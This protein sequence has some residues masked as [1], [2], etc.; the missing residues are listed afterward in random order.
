MRATQILRTEHRVIEQVLSCLEA[1]A[2]RACFCGAVD[3]ESA[4]AAIDFFRNFADE[5][6]HAKEESHLFAM[7]EERGFSSAGGPT[8][9]MRSEHRLGRQHLHVMEENLEL[10]EAGDP[11]ALT[12]FVDAAWE[13]V[14]LL[15][16]HILKEDNCLF[17][18]ADRFLSGPD[19]T[20]LLERFEAAEDGGH[21]GKHARY[22]ALADKLAE[23]FGVT[24]AGEAPGCVH[25]GCGIQPGSS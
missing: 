12:R 9:V 17:P 13:Y 6:H 5:C 4:R 11:D 23:R 19:Q 3:G 18:M 7:M 22:V 25:G 8:A 20:A 16:E 24:P 15:R 21:A 14:T 1:M 2:D 10:A